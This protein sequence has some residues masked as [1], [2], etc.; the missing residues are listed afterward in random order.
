MFRIGRYG[1]GFAGEE[2]WMEN[3]RSNC[4]VGAGGD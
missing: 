1:R 2:V 4:V 3:E